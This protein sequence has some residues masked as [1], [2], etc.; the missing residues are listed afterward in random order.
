M[1]P[2]LIVF[3]GTN[4]WIDVMIGERVRN[5]IVNKYYVVIWKFTYS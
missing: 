3:D 5:Y 1:K 2:V 4:V